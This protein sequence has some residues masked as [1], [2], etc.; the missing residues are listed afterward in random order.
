MNPIPILAAFALLAG[1]AAAQD[2]P[3]YGA[4][5]EGFDYPHE[6]HRF[7][8]DSQGADL[9]MAF[10]DVPAAK[11][12]GRTVVLLHGKNFCAATWEGAISALT[13]AGYRVIAPDQIGFCKSSKPQA[14]QYSFHQLAQNTRAL[15]Q[16]LKVE[17][18]ILMA[19]SMGGM[20]AARYALLYPDEVSRLV[21][22]N[23]I[24]LE[25]WIAEGVP[26]ATVD[27]NYQSELNT[28]FERIKA[29][30]QK[31]YYD[32][33]WKA[34]Y[35]RWAEM[36]AGLY[37]GE[38]RETVAWNQ[39][40]ITDMVMTQPVVHEFPRLKVPV[41][42]MIG[43]KD[44]TAPGA[45]RAPEPV[46]KRLGDYPALGKRAEA[47]I[48]DATLIAFEALGHSPQIEDPAAFNAALRSALTEKS[49]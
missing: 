1:G 16:S 36:L 12:N 10:M 4:M 14:Y 43:Q 18:P 27:E 37:R 45:A 17:K 2:R 3:T 13:D 46:A 6:V 32:G 5:L 20:L 21:L 38:G 11:P 30:Q 22:V 8:I 48:P 15:L 26:Y 40:L 34:E 25:D 35:E 28:D 19:H 44:R 41:T 33:Q 24:G 47:A 29:Y 31:F 7:T 9:S 42:L 23:P 39:A 49:E